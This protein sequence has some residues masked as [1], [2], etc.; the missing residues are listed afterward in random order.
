MESIYTKINNIESKEDF[1]NFI[2]L[3]ISDYKTNVHTWENKTIEDYLEAM[4]NWVED[5]EGYFKYKNIPIPQKIEW[6]LF[7]NILIAAKMYE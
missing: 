7:A 5:M 6:N 3:L 2:N 4:A 1:V